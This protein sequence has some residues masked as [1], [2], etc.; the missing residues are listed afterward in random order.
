MAN[1]HAINIATKGVLSNSGEILAAKGYP[2]NITI[3]EIA[4]YHPEGGVDLTYGQPKHV[5]KRE[6]KKIIRVIVTYEGE[7]YIEERVVDDNVKITADDVE[8]NLTNKT[9]KIT[10][11]TIDF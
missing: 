6:K 5:E 10:I 3:S 1:P 11:R 9:P 2:F 8:I 4:I 7:K